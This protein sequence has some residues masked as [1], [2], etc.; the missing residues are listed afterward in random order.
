VVFVGQPLTFSY[1]KQHQSDRPYV[2]VIGGRDGVIRVPS[3]AGLAAVETA[4]ALGATAGVNATAANAAA[5]RALSFHEIESADPRLLA[6]ALTELRLLDSLADMSAAESSAIEK[7]SLDATVPSTLRAQL[8]TLVSEKGAVPLLQVLERVTAAPPIVMEAAL[9]AR[10]RLGAP[11]DMQEIHRLLDGK[12]ATVRAAAVPA[13]GLNGNPEA[14][15]DLGRYAIEDPAL[16]VRIAAID[17]LG[18]TGEPATLDWLVQCFE[19]DSRPIK[20]AAARAILSVG[21]EPANRTLLELA[22]NGRHSETRVYATALLLTRYGRDHPTIRRIKEADPGAAVRD[23]IAH[24]MQ[25]G[26]MH[27]H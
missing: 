19:S 24:G 2:A 15:A 16:G 20:Q 8:L 10:A 25:P 4:I 23:L 27:E 6:D 26:H 7:L 18:A 3:A 12:D 5:R 9:R 17:S 14:L 11:A 13:L 22:T 1:F 21:G